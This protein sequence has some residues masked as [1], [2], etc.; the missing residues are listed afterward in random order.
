MFTIPKHGV[1][2][3]AINREIQNR[4]YERKLFLNFGNKTQRH[5]YNCC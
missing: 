2:G 1:V 4:K 5:F 3:K